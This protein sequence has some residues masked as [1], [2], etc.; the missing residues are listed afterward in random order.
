M[1][2]NEMRIALKNRLAEPQVKELKQAV[3]TH[4]KYYNPDGSY[5]VY[6]ENQRLASDIKNWNSG[7]WK[8]NGKYKQPVK[9]KLF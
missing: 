5:S 4:K 6:K 1:N 3:E 7:G 2:F 8:N 9:H